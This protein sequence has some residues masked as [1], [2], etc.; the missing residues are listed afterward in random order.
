MRGIGLL[1]RRPGCPSLASV[2]SLSSR[3]LWFSSTRSTLCPHQTQVTQQQQGEGVLKGS[4]KRQAEDKWK[5]PNSPCRTRFAPSP[6]GYLHL[7]SLRTAL[8]NYLLAKATGGQFILRIEDTD[9]TRLVH[10][11]E[12]RLFDDLRWAGLSWDEGPDVQGPYGPYRQS[13]RLLLYDEHANQLIREGKAYRCF[14]SP[15]NLERHKQAAHESGESTAYPGTCRNVSLEESDDRAAK[16]EKYAVRFKSSDK[17]IIIEDIL[18]TRYRKREPEEDFIIRKRDGFPT[19][20]FANIVDDRAMKI[21]HVIRGAEW[22]IS[23]PKH[24]ELYNA[25]GWEPPKFAHVGLLVDKERQKLS[26]RHKGVDM[27]WYK[28]NQI[29]PEALLNFAVLLGWSQKSGEPDFMTLQDMVDR[30]SFKF[31]K[32]DIV[33]SFDKL[34]YLHEKHFEHLLRQEPPNLPRLQSYLINPIRD[35][36]TA[37][38]DAR[39]ETPKGA[40]EETTLHNIPL[41]SLASPVPQTQES[42]ASAQDYILRALR[43]A[44]SIKPDLELFLSQNRYAFWTIPPS[45]LSKNFDET[46]S[47]QHAKLDGEEARPSV[48]MRFI[49]EQLSDIVSSKGEEGSPEEKKAE[50]EEWTAERIK[51]VVDATVKAVSVSDP[52]TGEPIKGAG[53]YKFLRWALLAGDHGPGLVSVMELL[54]R[55]ETMKRLITSYKIA[56]EKEKAENEGGGSGTMDAVATGLGLA[57]F[58]LF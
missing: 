47:L 51:P 24:V 15:E 45:V 5:L 56:L 3:R 49:V 1:L 4:K 31:S 34:P 14:C 53:G 41:P 46:P 13:E 35:M 33:V 11:A 28:D 39:A 50:A 54:G 58:D 7:G 27:S 40:L 12:Q 43:T 10:D 21:T 19:Y 8:F 6:T 48:V 20:H 18:Y 9:Q 16:G 55:K 52:E 42:P 37:V 22:L 17:P 57:L 38:E 29:P 23:T 26:K 36:I 44:K 30:F 25:F 2:S 32:G